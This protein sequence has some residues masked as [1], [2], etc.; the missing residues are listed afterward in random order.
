MTNLTSE[1]EQIAH[2]AKT[3][4]ISRNPKS[5]VS[6]RAKKVFQLA[7]EL[8]SRGFVVKV[9]DEIDRLCQLVDQFTHD[10]TLRTVVSA[11][12]DGT[13]SLLVN[14]LPS[15]IPITI[16]PMGTANLLANYVKA[17]LDID[18]TVATIERGNVIR[19]D[20]GRANGRLFVVV[21]SI[22]FDADVVRRI[23]SN[24]KGHIN[25]L[26]YASPIIGSILGY[27][28]PTMRLRADD[29]ALPNARWT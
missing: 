7:D 29:R 24:R 12:G 21:A 1:N 27:S 8:E 26:S 18:K 5:G 13:V 2:D 25:Y 6:G 16:F 11:G 22:G 19:M 3:I 23:H 15:N 14:Q 28:F 17:S 10:G 4:V 9:V 20:C